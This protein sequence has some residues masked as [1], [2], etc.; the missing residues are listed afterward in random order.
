MGSLKERIA[1]DGI[2]VTA[3]AKRLNISREALYNK[4]NAE[5]EFRASEIAK[6][7][8]ILNLTSEEQREY[9]FAQNS[10]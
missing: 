10:D 5:T 8:S 4:L 3:L 2:S 1:G 6:L 7:I 9:F